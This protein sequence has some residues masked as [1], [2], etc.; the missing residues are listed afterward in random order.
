MLMYFSLRSLLLTFAVGTFVI[1]PTS[2]GAQQAP[3][4]AQGVVLEPSGFERLAAGPTAIFQIRPSLNGIVDT[5]ANRLVFIDDQGRI[6]GRS[7]LPDGFSVSAVEAEDDRI[8]LLGGDRKSAIILARSIDPTALGSLAEE[9]LPAQPRSA[10]AASVRRSK[11]QLTIPSALGGARSNA[12]QLEVRSLTGGLLA[13]ATEVGAST[14]GDRYVLWT[15]LVSANPS[16]VVRAFVGRYSAAGRLTGVAEVP[17]ADMDYVPEQY[18]VVSAGGDVRVMV[19]TKSRLELRTLAI[20]SITPVDP[21]TRSNVVSPD[22]LKRLPANKGRVVPV[23]TDVRTPQDAPEPRNLSPTTKEDREGRAVVP[24]SRDKVL[25]QAR[26]FITQQW[27]LAKTNY[28]QPGVADVCNKAQRQYWSRPSWVRE[29]LIDQ[30]LTRIPYKWGGFDDPAEY[31]RRLGQGYLA[32]SVCTCRDPSHNDCVV[33]KAAGVDCSGFVSRAWGLVRKYGTSN[34]SS[35]STILKNWQSDLDKLKPGDA[36]NR[37]GNHVRLVAQV[38]SSPQ[39]RIVVLE[40]TTARTCK[41]LDGTLNV[42]EGVCECARPIAEFSGYQL[43]RYKGIQ[44]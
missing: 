31:V 40:S 7:P 15:E 12:G 30:S 26:A 3:G 4:A 11:T 39:V 34:L 22:L 19:P 1:W 43:L 44:D 24:I 20:S 33:E 28:S 2:L 27:T 38:T 5:L 32:G 42:C 29:Q 41:R 8:L 10:P 16:A 6:V 21:L 9:P 37:S 13:D 25:D 18:V 17:I 14:S 23:A 35:I 36:L